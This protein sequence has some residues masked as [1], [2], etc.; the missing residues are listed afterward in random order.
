MMLLFKVTFLLILKLNGTLFVIQFCIELFRVM[1]VLDP[2]KVT[3]QNFDK[4]YCIC[5]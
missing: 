3:I 5:M 2:I 1:A 4:V